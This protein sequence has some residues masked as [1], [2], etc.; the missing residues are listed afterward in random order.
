METTKLLLLSL[1][2]AE[3]LMPPLRVILEKVD[4]AAL[5]V[6]TEVLSHAMEDYWPFLSSVFEHERPDILLLCLPSKS[7]PG[8]EA[9]FSAVRQHRWDMPVLVVLESCEIVELSKAIDSR[10]TDFI[11]APFRPEE[12]VPR[13]LRLCSYAREGSATARNLKER[14]GLKQLIGESPVFVA[15]IEKIP[16][17][18]RCDASVLISGETGTGKEMFA[19]AIHYLSPRSDRPFIPVDC[20]AIPLDLVE[21]E[22]FGHEAGA[23]T[24]ANSSTLGVVYDS[25]GGT[26]FLDEIDS[27]PLQ[28]QVKLLRFLQ[29]KE[30]RPLGS[31]K[32]CKADTRVIAA[33]NTEFQSAMRSG[34]FRADLYYRLNVVSLCLPPLRRRKEDIPLLARHFVAKFSLECRLPPKALS[35][36]VIHKLL[37]YE[38]PGNIRELENVVSRAVILSERPVIGCED[39]QLPSQSPETGPASFK[40]LKAKAIAEFETSYI[41]QLLAENDGNITRAA[42]A[43]KKHRRAFWQLMHKH[44]I[45]FSTRDPQHKAGWTNG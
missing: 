29:G 6:S 43:A 36:A 20:G 16:K 8:G 7:A 14:L 17:I 28:S 5:Q 19:R 18:A 13:L 37:S 35:P 27:L 38:W 2:G 33:S 45:S 32:V 4:L 41:R 23:F 11:L 10:A 31:R 25:D 39:I 26:L 40:F 1:P 44:R 34:R 9:V 21:N 15:E 3:A 22:L 24:G 12:I 42:N 30:Y